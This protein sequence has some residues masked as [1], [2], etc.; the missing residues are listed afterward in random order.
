MTKSVPVLHVAF[1]PGQQREQG[2]EVHVPTAAGLE[3][4]A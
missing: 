3:G 2:G 1:V 4:R